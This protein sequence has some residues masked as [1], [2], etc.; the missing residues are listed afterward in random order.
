MAPSTRAFDIVNLRRPIMLWHWTAG[1]NTLEVSPPTRQ[2]TLS[3]PRAGSAGARAESRACGAGAVYGAS[4]GSSE[5]VGGG[6][7]GVLVAAAPLCARSR[8]FVLYRA[9]R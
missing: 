1:A 9:K 6:S 2:V 5:S 7:D 3:S 8:A 4:K